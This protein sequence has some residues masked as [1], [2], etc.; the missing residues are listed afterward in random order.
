MVIPSCPCTNLH[1]TPLNGQNQSSHVHDEF[2]L[3]QD[4]S[5]ITGQLFSIKKD[6]NIYLSNLLSM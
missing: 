5:P 3:S 6:T 1:T 2:E 4:D